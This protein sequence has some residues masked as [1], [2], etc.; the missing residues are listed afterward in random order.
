MRIEEAQKVAATIYADTAVIASRLGAAMRQLDE[1]TADGFPNHTPMSSESSGAPPLDDD[2]T[3][4]VST[5]V[6]RAAF[7]PDKAEQAQDLLVRTLVHAERTTHALRKIVERVTQ[8]PPVR[9]GDPE[10]D[11]WCTHHARFGMTEPATPKRDGLCEWCY[12]FRAAHNP[13][14]VEPLVMPTKRL[15]EYRSERGRVSA[16]DVARLAPQTVK[17]EQKKGKK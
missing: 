3:V 5:P 13:V 1:W 17:A 4:I 6:E 16:A 7:T 11:I 10:S 9:P 14:R 12:S 15:L 8:A 2:G